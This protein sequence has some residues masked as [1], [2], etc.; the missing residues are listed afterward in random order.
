MLQPGDILNGEYQI[1]EEIGEGGG[2]IVYKAKHLKLNIFV[3]VKQV[4]ENVKDK[5]Y[6]RQ[7]ADILI[8]L[9]NEYLPRIYNFLEIDSEIYTVMDYIEGDTL[10]KVIETR[11]N[12]S[13]VDIIKWGRQLSNALEFLHK[14]TPPII[15]SDIKP[16]NIIITPD[17]NATL[18]DFNISV[19]FDDSEKYSVGISLGYA[20][21]EQCQDIE[22]YKK[23]YRHQ[24]KL[25]IDIDPDSIVGQFFSTTKSNLAQGINK[26]P[27]TNTL[28]IK[29]ETN[30][31]DI[32]H[33]VYLFNN[34]EAGKK[35]FGKH[36]TVLLHNEELSEIKDGG[37]EIVD[38]GTLIIKN[39]VYRY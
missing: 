33:T 10:D 34:K 17:G 3:V 20:P 39:Y 24:T 38:N 30:N 36:G 35:D 31:D 15:H 11:K 13:Q 14:Q 19:L 22:T 26:K 4:K 5:I 8:K 1:I 27:K 21:P 23:A 25:D 9:K 29:N 37:T 32:P 18:I 16:S 28:I 12:I 2:G 6:R 7:E